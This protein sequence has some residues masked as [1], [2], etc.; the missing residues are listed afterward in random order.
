MRVLYRKKKSGKIFFFASRICIF[1]ARPQIKFNDREQSESGKKW[2]VPFPGIGAE[3]LLRNR[4][5]IT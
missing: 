4:E 3:I 2:P 5:K 1:F